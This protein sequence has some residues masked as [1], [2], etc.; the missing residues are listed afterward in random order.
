MGP[1]SAGDEM[2]TF[3]V[4]PRASRFRASRPAGTTPVHFG[5]TAQLPAGVKTPMAKAPPQGVHFSPLTPM[6][7]IVVGCAS[8]GP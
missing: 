2:T 1:L 8:M 6:G 4:A 5:S 3:K 7:F